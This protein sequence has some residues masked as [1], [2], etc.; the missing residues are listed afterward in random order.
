ML[1][2]APPVILKSYTRPRAWLM[3]EIVVKTGLIDHATTGP[4]HDDLHTRS[5]RASGY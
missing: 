3:S 5:Q 4:D 1:A 2:I